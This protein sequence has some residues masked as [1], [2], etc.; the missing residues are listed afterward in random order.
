MKEILGYQ[1]DEVAAASRM[2]SQGVLPHSHEFHLAVQEATPTKTTLE[3]IALLLIRITLTRLTSTET[4]NYLVTKLVG[5]AL[6]L[7]KLNKKFAVV[8]SCFQKQ[9]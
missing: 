7:R 9:P 2:A 1:V 8:R 3:N 6:K 4:A 5:V